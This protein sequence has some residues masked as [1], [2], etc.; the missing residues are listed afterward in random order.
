MCYNCPIVICHDGL[1]AKSHLHHTVAGHVFRRGDGHVRNHRTIGATPVT[2][3]VEQ[4]A[5]TALLAVDLNVSS[6]ESASI[7]GAPEY[8]RSSERRSSV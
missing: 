5:K 7:D 3:H 6:V 1:Q 2:Q 8:I 4:S